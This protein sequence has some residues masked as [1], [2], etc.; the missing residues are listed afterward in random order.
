MLSM[1]TRKRLRHVALV[2]V[3]VSFVLL[4]MGAVTLASMPV[5]VVALVVTAAVAVVSAVAF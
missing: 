5:T 3:I 1:N 4:Y 2:G